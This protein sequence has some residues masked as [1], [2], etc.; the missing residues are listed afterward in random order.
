MY[1]VDFIKSFDEL[2]PDAS[3]FLKN[4]R[5]IYLRTLRFNRGDLQT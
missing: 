4:Y 1:G 2:L 5:I 3:Q